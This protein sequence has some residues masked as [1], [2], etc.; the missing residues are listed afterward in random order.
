M[1]FQIIWRLFFHADI[2]FGVIHDRANTWLGPAGM[3]KRF[4]DAL[5]ANEEMVGRNVT[6]NLF[7]RH[8]RPIFG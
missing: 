1:T 6:E 2:S 3:G 8:L 7:D 5:E 4:T